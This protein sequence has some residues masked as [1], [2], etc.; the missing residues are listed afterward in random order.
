MDMNSRVCYLRGK[1][2]EHGEIKKFLNSR[3]IVH[4]DTTNIPFED[5]VGKALQGKRQKYHIKPRCWDDG[6]LVVFPA[7]SHSG[8]VFEAQFFKKSLLPRKLYLSRKRRI[9]RLKRSANF[10]DELNQEDVRILVSR[11]SQGSKKI[12]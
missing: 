11:V 8:E 2:N 1:Y 10:M 4:I 12:C 7:V 3:E 9:Q 5:Y 6:D